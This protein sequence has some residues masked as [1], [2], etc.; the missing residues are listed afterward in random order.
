MKK[1]RLFTLLSF[2]LMLAML[3]FVGCNNEEKISSLSLKD[4]EPDSIIEAA[5]GEFD[6]TDYTLVVSYDSGRTEEVKVTEEMIPDTDIF[7][8]YSEGEHDITVSY[9]KHEYVIKV[10]VKRSTFGTLTLPETNVFTYD[11]AAHSVEVIG[12]MPANAVVTYLGGNSFVNA[13]TYDVTAIVSC[14]GY[15]TVKLYT[16]VKIERAVYDMSGVKFEAKEYVYDGGA[17]SVQISGTLPK[18]VAAPKYTINEKN[19]SSAVDVGEYTV[20]ATFLNSDTNYEPIPDMTTTLTITPAEYK[21][22]DVDIVFKKDGKVIEGA[23]RV[24]DG[25]AVTFDLN[26]YNKLSSR[27]SVSFSVYDGEGNKISG[28]NKNTNIINA[29]IYTVKAEFTLADG[30]NYK[31]IEPIVR[32]FEVLPAEYILEGVTINADTCTYDGEAHSIIISG[33]LPED[34]SVAYEYYLGGVQVVD[35]EGKPVQSVVNAGRYTVKAVFTHTDKNRA[36]IEPVSGVLHITRA[37][38]NTMHLSVGYSGELVD[39]GT[40][41]SVVLKG[42]LPED[43]EVRYEYYKD[44]KLVTNSDGTPA[45]AVSGAGEYTVKIIFNVKS[46]NYTPIEEMTHTFTILQG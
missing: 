29:G 17:H 38:Y 11:G 44:G 39:D 5:I 8:L 2:A 37:T 32:E 21:I 27:V 24:Y 19:T 46:G 36:Q 4:H 20:R 1:V 40:P 25:T 26:D 34:V 33:T 3:L 41:K 23:S 15:V 13:G 35:G 45:S 43:I 12:D 28:S 42:T 6:C 18:G 31:P 7:K 14:E 9:E 22:K 10:A 30:K 16:T